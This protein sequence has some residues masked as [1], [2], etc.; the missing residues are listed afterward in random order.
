MLSHLHSKHPSEYKRINEDD[1]SSSM[2]QST[3]SSVFKKC[4]A[5]RSAAITDTIAEFIAL[6]LCPIS[7]VNGKGFK[8]LMNFVE[9]GYRVPSYT[10]VTSVCRRKFLLLKENLLATLSQQCDVTL[11][12][13]IWT[14]RTIQAY[15]TITTHYL[16]EDWKMETK[17]LLTR[18]MP[19]RH[20]GMHI[21]ERLVNA[22]EEWKITEKISA[23]VHDNASN[24]VLASQ[25]H[26]EWDDLPCFG[27]T[28]QLAVNTGLDLNVISRLTAVC[29]RIV[30]HF[31]HSVV[32]TTAL[33]DK[34]K[35]MGIAQHK[36]IQ[37]VS[38]R[39]NSTYFMYE[40]LIE[41]RWTIYAVI[42]DEQ[43]TPSSQRNLDL[44]TD[45]RDLLDQ[46]VVVLKPLQI[47]TTALS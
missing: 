13:D 3:L 47:A 45:Q 15:L 17:V 12:T 10:H 8:N 41:Q 39:W 9:P 23:V 7:I 4:S 14:S 35:V 29:R 21:S 27:H 26:E 20:T 2:K 28:L 11:T 6:D 33:V 38:T 22:C 44:K 24:M 40:R 43:I 46:L 18:E 37:D 34:Q 19:E 16:T 30:N 36:L 1:S 25:L 32:A 5:N 42:H 31:K